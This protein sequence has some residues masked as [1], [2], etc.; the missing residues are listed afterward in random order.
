[1]SNL[2]PAPQPSSVV[3]RLGFALGFALA[4]LF[5][6]WLALSVFGVLQMT[7]M[8][9][10]FLKLA[11][12]AAAVWAA[13]IT[14][15]K[16]VEADDAAYERWRRRIE[17]LGKAQNPATEG[18]EFSTLL[19]RYPEWAEMIEAIHANP[20]YAKHVRGEGLAE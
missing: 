7:G 3:G 17:D 9:P 13:W 15:G 14:P 11:L 1:M 16:I 10:A 2:P 6:G 8:V 5:L 18:P 20:S 12:F 19:R 4:V